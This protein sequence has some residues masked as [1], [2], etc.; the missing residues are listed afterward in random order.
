MPADAEA[1]E[2]EQIAMFIRESWVIGDIAKKSPGLNYATAP[3][4]RG[5]IAVPVNLYVN[6]PGSGDAKAV[7][8]FTVAA[9][10]PQNLIWSLTMSAGCR[11]GPGLTIHRSPNASRPMTHLLTT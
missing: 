7:W 4:P 3:L 6:G 11:T 1:F 5:S 8:D 9:N 2:R 10:D